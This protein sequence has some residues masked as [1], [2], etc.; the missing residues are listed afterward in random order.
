MTFI[1]RVRLFLLAWIIGLLFPLAWL[2]SSNYRNIFD[3]IFAP[4]WVHILLH[5]LLYAVLS[6]LLVLALGL[7]TNWTSIFKTLMI[8]LMVGT[9]QETLQWVSQGNLYLGQAMIRNAGFD[10]IV[11]LIGS[12][13][14]LAILYRLQDR[15]GQSIKQLN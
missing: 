9:I 8:V 10:I 11:D 6:M 4:E 2:G 1:M 14:G 5:T 7:S 15:K 13:I 3:N 12:L